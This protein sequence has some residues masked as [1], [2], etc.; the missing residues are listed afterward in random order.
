MTV[1]IDSN[2]IVGLWSPDDALNPGA[3]KALV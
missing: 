2:V 3:R 1:S